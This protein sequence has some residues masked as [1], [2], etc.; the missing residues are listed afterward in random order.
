MYRKFKQQLLNEMEM[1]RDMIVLKTSEPSLEP[2]FEVSSTDDKLYR[3]ILSEFDIIAVRHVENLIYN[4]CLKYK[5]NAEMNGSNKSIFDLKMSINGEDCFIDFKSSPKSFNS[6]KFNA[7]IDYVQSCQH[8]VYLVYL[9]KDSIHSR[10]E[11][12]KQKLQMYEKKKLHNLK[13]ILFE[14]F[15]LEQFGSNELNL[16][17]KEMMTYKDEMHQVVGY[18]ITEIFNS[19]NLALLKTEVEQDILNFEY[20]RLKSD[21]YMEIR[22]INGKHKDLYDM[23]FETIKSF[24]LKQ[25]R[26]MLLFGNSDFAKSFLTSEWLKKRYFSLSEMDNTFIVAGYLKSIEQLLWKIICI[27]GRGRK[28]K[29]VTIEESN[30]EDIDT[31]LGSLQHFIT[32]YDNDDLFEIAFGSSNHYVMKYLQNQLSLWRRKYRNGYFH[33]HNLENKK[34]VDAIRDETYFLYLLILGSISLDDDAMTALNI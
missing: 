10:N 20:N 33:K 22:S 23:N 16:F 15:L 14:D 1:R 17:K 7:F 30:Y 27:V 2:I 3:R 6:L 8:P 12:T 19:H 24:F 9:L 11:I 29:E 13:I 26:Y 21:K 32:N 5:I 34:Q 25:K 18:Q 4:L 31:T 28:I